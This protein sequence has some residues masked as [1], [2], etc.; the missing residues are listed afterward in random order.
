MKAIFRRLIIYL[1]GLL[2]VYLFTEWLIYGII[3]AIFQPDSYITFENSMIHLT[4]YFAVA[5]LLA[6]IGFRHIELTKAGKNFLSVILIGSILGL[7]VTPLWFNAADEENI[8]KFRVFFSTNYS[9]DEVD[10]VSTHIY[11]INSRSG[12]AR[13]GQRRVIEEY[14]L[15]FT[16][17]TAL[18]VWSD[19]NSIY[20]L[21]QLALEKELPVKHLTEVEQF[22]QRFANYFKENLAKAYLVFGIK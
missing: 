16:D 5:I 20:N 13:S 11:R 17:G 1:I 3:S 12:S 6:L 10:E 14:N 4:K 21:H 15:H 7:F 9:W 2:L 22:E 8:V 19:L 18:N